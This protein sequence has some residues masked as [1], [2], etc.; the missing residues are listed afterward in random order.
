VAERKR[1]QDIFNEVY[2]D[3]EKAKRVRSSRIRMFYEE[4]TLEFGIRGLDTARYN[5]LD[6]GC[7]RGIF[8][9]FLADRFCRVVGSDFAEKAVMTAKKVFPEKRIDFLSSDAVSLPVKDQSFDFIV[10]KDF[11]HHLT[12]PEKVMQEI[13]RVMRPGG[14]LIS[15]EPNNRNLLS[16]IIGRMMRHERKFVE[17]SPSTLMRFI[18]RFGFRKVHTVCENFYVPYGPFYKLPL[19]VLPYL[20]VFE[21][22]MGRIFPSGGGHFIACYQK[23]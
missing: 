6:L 9:Q 11:I 2:G 16:Q 8:T 4:R 23:V 14:Y 5:C 13:H 15:V 3:V 21:D 17:N 1:Q 7:G 19:R 20:Q 18:S 10:I 12:D 22:M